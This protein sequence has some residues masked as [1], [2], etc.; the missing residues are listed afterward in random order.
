MTA[1]GRGWLGAVRAAVGFLTRLPV[2]HRE[3]DWDAFRSRPA[4]FPL[5][6]LVAGSL[7]AVPLLAADALPAPTVALGYLL[8]VYAVT[9]IHHLDGIAD[10]G[11]ALV[12][13]GDAARRREVLKDTT[14][15]VGAVLAVA[16]TVAALALAG[17]GL[18]GLS[19]LTAVA[20]AIAAEV[21]AKLGMAAMACF[22][23]A[24]FEGMGRQFTEPSTPG[25]FV[26]PAG[27]LAGAT[28]LVWPHPAAVAPWAALAG[29]GLPWYWADRN[30]GGIN[31]DVFGAANELGRVV[32]VH[33]GVIAWTLS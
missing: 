1:R 18:A 13:H 14:T 33:A 17:L 23:T 32:G 31:G 5:V 8:A 20:V 25:G 4:A 16:L 12:V 30:L 3:G 7:A 21:G 22:G 9:G 26:V 15:G 19:P 11:D 29:I 28:A 10:L 2:P 6:G 24:G 27:V